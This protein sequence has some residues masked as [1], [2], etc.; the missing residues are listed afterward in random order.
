MNFDCYVL[1]DRQSERRERHFVEVSVC[2]F[3]SLSGALDL[4]VRRYGG[5]CVNTTNSLH[6]IFSL[7]SR[8]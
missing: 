7:C 4:P 5:Y 3:L 8:V 6:R 1:D 2:A